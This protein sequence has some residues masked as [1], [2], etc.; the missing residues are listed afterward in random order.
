MP[1]PTSRNEVMSNWL[2]NWNQP[3]P[4]PRKLALV[5]RNLSL[6]VV[7]RSTCCGHPGQPGC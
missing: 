1:Q 7:K 4:L 2:T 5:M 3:L 6:R